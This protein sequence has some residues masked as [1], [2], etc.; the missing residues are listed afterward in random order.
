MV[1]VPRP[2]PTFSLPVSVSGCQKTTQRYNHM[3]AFK[4]GPVPS[5]WQWKGPLPQYHLRT[6]CVDLLRDDS[7]RL[8]KSQ[9]QS[10]LCTCWKTAQGHR[11]DLASL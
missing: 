6:Q 9:R 2:D 4:S 3:G 10:S 5:C 7:Q 8:P 1:L 11:C